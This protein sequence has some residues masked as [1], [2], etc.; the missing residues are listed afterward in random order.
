MHECAA[1]C[2]RRQM[3]VRGRAAGW[4]GGEACV[5]VL[6]VT[7]HHHAPSEAAS[8]RQTVPAPPCLHRAARGRQR[9]QP[10]RHQP[11]PAHGRPQGAKRGARGAAGGQEECQMPRPAPTDSR[12][13]RRPAWQHA[14]GPGTRGGRAPQQAVAAFAPL[15]APDCARGAG[16]EASEDTGAVTQRR[17]R[18]PSSPPHPPPPPH[19]HRHVTAPPGSGPQPPAAG[20]GTKT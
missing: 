13:R 17:P 14:F 18:P 8:R 9:A 16:P 6:Q 1:P 5:C 10:L 20:C 15:S 2:A 7:G 19:T 3:P 11:V 12:Q 4:G